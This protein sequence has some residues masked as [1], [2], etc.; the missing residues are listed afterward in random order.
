[1]GHEP[2][3]PRLVDS[4]L[5]MLHDPVDKSMSTAEDL[6]TWCSTTPGMNTFQPIAAAAVEVCRAANLVGVFQHFISA[7]ACTPS[8]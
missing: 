1:M 8:F 5:I 7:A 2:H 6:S 4:N 3:H